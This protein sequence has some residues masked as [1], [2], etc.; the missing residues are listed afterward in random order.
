MLNFC[1]LL[2]ETSNTDSGYLIII[3]TIIVLNS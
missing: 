1:L 3:F 2:E